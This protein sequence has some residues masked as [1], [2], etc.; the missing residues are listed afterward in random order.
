[1]PEDSSQKSA[2]SWQ[3]TAA[4]SMRLA[5]LSQHVVQF[6]S[7]IAISVQMR[8]IPP[9]DFAIFGLAVLLV[10]F[11]RMLTTMG[12]GAAIIQKSRIDADQLSFLF[13]LN[14]VFGVVAMLVSILAA[15]LV[16]K[17]GDPGGLLAVTAVLASGSLFVA[18]ARVPQAVLEREL[19][20]AVLA[21]S[22]WIAM[23]IASA[24]SIAMGIAGF[25]IWAL[26]AHQWL[27]VVLFS[28]LLW[29]HIAWRP[30]RPSWRGYSRDLFH[31]ANAF[32]LSQWIQWLGQRFDRYWLW[33]TLGGTAMG[34]EWVGLYTQNMNLVLRPALMLTG[35]L[36][37]ILLS[38][39]SRTHGDKR[40]L[41]NLH[42]SV[43][44]LGAIVLCPICLG[45]IVTAEESLYVLGGPKWRPAAM[46]LASMGLLMI[47]RAAINL[48]VIALSASGKPRLL[49][50]VAFSAAS[51]LVLF[52]ITSTMI[53]KKY[54]A[55]PEGM[56]LAVAIGQTTATAILIL[57]PMLWLCSRALETRF[58]SLFLPWLKPFGV[59]ILMAAVVWGVKVAPIPWGALP[60]AAKLM[61]LATIGA[62]VYTLPML[63]DLRWALTFIRRGSFGESGAEL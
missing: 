13:W 35:P 39:L 58:S 8:L 40:V 56:S 24:T 36:S 18:V 1:V 52:A 26:V 50:A 43:M 53:A 49:L 42:Q 61:F 60:I 5:L 47:M 3:A 10:E 20:I 27:E 14:Q 48:S 63:S 57:F 17:P 30:S 51:V 32:T 21:R 41:E 38:A 37:G 44:R 7:L 55:S 29:P 59:S 11:P 9:A 23:G 4:S 54:A 25:R 45:L 33:R 31:F 22:Q 12:V 34:P 16:M 6:L 46:L 15:P 19:R 28:L 2:A 62:A